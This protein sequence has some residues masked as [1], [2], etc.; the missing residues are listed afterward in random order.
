MIWGLLELYEATFNIRYIKQALDFLKIQNENFWDDYIGGYF[1]TSNED[2]ELLTRQKNIYDGAI[3]SG[4]SVAL[5]NLLR[6]GQITG[7]PGLEEK[8]DILSRVFSEKVESNPDAY[9]Q[10][11]VAADFAI[12]PSYSLVVAGK[13]NNDD[14][15]KMIETINDNYI[16]NK[17]FIQRKT[18]QNPPDID[19]I[20]NFVQY[21][22]DEGGKATAYICINKT[23]KPATQDLDK[24][25]EY[26]K[27]EW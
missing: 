9:T 22:E 15:I 18:E 13:T 4:N 27:A 5:L 17:V 11:M 16:P 8:A 2:E 23:C 21:F 12:G 14:T 25:I 24:V 20:S 6:L 19:C 26:L 10:L 3:P 1:F 7:D